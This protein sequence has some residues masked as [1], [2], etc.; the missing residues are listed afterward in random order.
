VRLAEA[1][2]RLSQPEP[3]VTGPR[4][5]VVHG[6]GGVGMQNNCVFTLEV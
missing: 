3:Y 4:R 6:A 5:A 2:R 1:A